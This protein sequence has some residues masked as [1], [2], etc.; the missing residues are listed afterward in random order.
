M[1]D[2]SIRSGELRH[3]IQ[4]VQRNLTQGS[5]G[6]TVEDDAS[7]FATVWAKV[8]DLEGKELYAAQQKVSEVTHKITMRW[9]GGIKAKMNVW[10]DDREFQIEY[11]T[12]PLQIRHKLILFCV[13]RDDSAR[14]GTP[15]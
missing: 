13:E 6:G 14:E 7:I 1:P 5:S 10:F 3:R 4:I 9:M 2:T 11:V 15:G 8:E 12:R